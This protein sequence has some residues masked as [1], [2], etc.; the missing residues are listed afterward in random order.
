MTETENR[1]WRRLIG[2]REFYRRVLLVVVPIMIQS[3]IT[4]FVGMLDNVMV[5]QIGT[6]QMSGVSIVNQLLFVYNL[7]CFGGFAG[8]GIFTAQFFGRG[9]DE[10][11]RHTFRFKLYLALGIFA[12][13]LFVLTVFEGPL[14]RSYLGQESG[15]GDAEATFGYAA[16]YLLWMLAGLFPFALSQVYASTQRECGETLIPMYSGIA[17]V[18][19]NL[20]FNYILIYGKFGAP[21]LGVVG[22]AI[23]TVLSRF[24]EMLILVIYVHTHPKKY[25]Y[26]V[27]L[28]RSF[29]VPAALAKSIVIKGSPL[30][31]NEFLWSA[32][33]AS[34]LQR[35]SVRGLEVIAA[36]NISMTISNVFNVVFISM[37]SATAIILGQELGA[38]DPHVRDDADRLAV[39]SVG[40]CVVSGAMLFGMSYL[41]PQIY[42]TEP[43]VRLLAGRFIRV[44]AVCSPIHAYANILYFT[45]RSGGKTLI[46]FLFDSC[47]IWVVSIPAA[48]LLTRYT[49]IPIGTVYLM[50]QLLEIVKCLFGGILVRK[51][52]W[53]HDITR[54]GKA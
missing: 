51:G 5:G 11:V 45:L 47:F 20:V 37:G 50:V 43:E 49:G 15:I 42:N 31:L 16:E 4:N 35:Y 29:R 39:T 9:D 18:F 54:L 10:G 52:V 48:H 12:A 22:A 40:A 27:G 32:G 1:G 21:A 30:L 2:S 8:A 33:M 28:Y 26:A 19:V 41:F 36:F 25:P 46:T 24:V 14:I 44:A 6:D 13:G 17:A 53:V 3:G 38:G 34:L 7:C 23:A